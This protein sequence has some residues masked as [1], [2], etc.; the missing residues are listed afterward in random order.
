MSLLPVLMQAA[1]PFAVFNETNL[2]MGLIVTTGDF[3]LR[4]I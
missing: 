4:S 3:A 2:E 1:L